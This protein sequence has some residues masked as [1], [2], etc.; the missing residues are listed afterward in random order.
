[1]TLI[2]DLVAKPRAN[3]GCTSLESS[4][5]PRI[6]PAKLEPSLEGL[7]S[8]YATAKD[9]QYPVGGPLAGECPPGLASTWVGRVVWAP[10]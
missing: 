8:T 3:A 9:L 5:A 2:S 4:R 6:V 7:A 10:G 1:M